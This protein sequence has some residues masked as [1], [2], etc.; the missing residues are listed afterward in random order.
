MVR[1]IAWEEIASVLPHID[2]VTPIKEGFVAYSSGRAMLSPVGELPMPAGEVHIKSGFIGGEAHFVVKVATGFYGNP[3]RGLSSSNGLFAIFDAECGAP[4]AILLDEGRLT[5]IRTAI[6]GA[7]AA[8][9]L[10]PANV[11]AVGVLGAGTQARLQLEYLKPI[12]KCRRAV[13][14][15]RRREA[16]ERYCHDLA[17]A[18]FDVVLADEPAE[19]AQRANLIVTATPSAAPVL[20]ADDIRPGTHITAIG[21]DSPGKNELDPLLLARADLLVAD[22]LAQCRERGDIAHA[23]EARC[24]REDKIVELGTILSGETRGRT[25]M[26]QITIA[27]ITGVAVQDLKI[28]QAVYS[29]VMAERGTA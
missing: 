11:T 1:V 9:C 20:H 13:V 12:T 19:V 23:L 24:L 15:A 5:D 28:A 14:W 7:I 26:D 6:A 29:A 10:A 3:A 4:V 2:L 27:D 22:S 17:C 16:A 18:G 21:A 25:Q 8:E